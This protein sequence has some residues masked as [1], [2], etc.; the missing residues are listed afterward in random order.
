MHVSHACMRLALLPGSAPTVH[1]ERQQSTGVAVHARG[2]G[3]CWSHRCTCAAWQWTP[4]ARRFRPGSNQPLQ[5][6]VGRHMG[7]L[8]RGRGHSRGAGTHVG[9]EV[10]TGF[11]DVGGGHVLH[12][13]GVA[14]VA[15]A[16]PRQVQHSPR[17]C[18]LVVLPQ[19]LHMAETAES[20]VATVA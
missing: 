16:Q 2:S 6:P 8:P 5:H 19:H 14:L 12:E 4:P 10:G 1:S 13:D 11:E 7:C 20:W 3:C 17:D 15:A 9:H 18:L